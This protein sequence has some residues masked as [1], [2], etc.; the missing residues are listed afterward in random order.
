M[1][2]ASFG[3]DG[4]LMWIDSLLQQPLENKVLKQILKDVSR[5]MSQ[6]ALFAVADGPGQK[7]LFAVLKCIANSFPDVGYAQGMNYVAAHLLLYLT[8][9]DAFLTFHQLMT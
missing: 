6:F 3:V 7:S 9:H 1:E 4:S 5:T 2:F 8:P